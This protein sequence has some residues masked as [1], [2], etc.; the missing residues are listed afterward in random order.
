[1]IRLAILGTCLL[2]ASLPVAVTAADRESGIELGKPFPLVLLPVVGN[3]E[4]KLQSIEPYRGRKL[5]VHLF[6]SW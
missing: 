5:M 1:M 3:E 6:A 4:G 2:A